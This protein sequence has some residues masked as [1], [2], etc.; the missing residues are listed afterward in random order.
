[1]L[2]YVII[3][4]YTYVTAFRRC[5]LQLLVVVAYVHTHNTAI[6][7]PSDDP[8]DA[9]YQPLNFAA[10]HNTK[11]FLCRP[12]CP[13]QAFCLT[14]FQC[15]H[16]CQAPPHTVSHVLGKYAQLS[17]SPSQLWGRVQARVC[18][19]SGIAFPRR[20][21]SHRHSHGQPLPARRRK[22]THGSRIFTVFLGGNAM[23]LTL[24]ADRWIM[25]ESLARW[26]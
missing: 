7:L 2:L 10:Q 20:V 6:L 8:H 21:Q 22:V 15:I 18:I 24:D 26:N 23:K 3:T 14:S 11:V 19:K 12:T 1:M 17:D 25:P 4:F 5:I 13:L 16:Y 9:P